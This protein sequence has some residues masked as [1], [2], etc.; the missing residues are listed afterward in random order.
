MKVRVAPAAPTGCLSKWGAPFAG[1]RSGARQRAP[2]PSM[3]SPEPRLPPSTAGRGP[4][5]ACIWPVLH[6]CRD[7]RSALEMEYHMLGAACL[8]DTQ[9]GTPKGG[10]PVRSPR[11]RSGRR[12]ANFRSGQLFQQILAQGRVQRGTQ[13]NRRPGEG[14]AQ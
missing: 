1:A 8:A 6:G 10:Q 3:L 2:L 5:P 14:M 11:S 12:W 7:P 4:C 9:K 13:R